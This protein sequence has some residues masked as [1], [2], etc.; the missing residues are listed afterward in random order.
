MGK[1]KEKQF[2]KRIHVKSRF[3]LCTAL[4][5]RSGSW[6]GGKSVRRFRQMSNLYRTIKYT[7]RQ[8]FFKRYMPVKKLECPPENLTEGLY[9]FAVWNRLPVFWIEIF[10]EQFKMRSFVMLSVRLVVSEFGSEFLA[11]SYRNTFPNPLPELDNAESTRKHPSGM[12]RVQAVKFTKPH[13]LSSLAEA[14]TIWADI[15]S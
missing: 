11:L 4:H 3:L 7:E 12:R 6:F 5:R 1:R 10:D 13:N 9:E 2:E 14:G 15:F 8:I